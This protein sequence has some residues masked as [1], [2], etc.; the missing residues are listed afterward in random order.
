MT[1][2]TVGEHFNE[3]LLVH[4]R[5]KTLE[6][7]LKAAAQMRPG[8][9]EKDAREILSKI[10]K[11]MGSEAS[12][13]RAQLRLGKHTALGFGVKGEDTPVLQEN[14]IFFFDLGLV[15]KGHEGDVGR[16]FVVGN[17]PEMLRCAQDAEIIWKEVRDHWKSEG[18]TGEELY[19]F[20]HQSAEKRSWALQLKG[21]KGHRIADF[22]HI[23]RQ[24]GTISRQAATLAENRWILEIQIIHP[25]RGFG[26]FYEDLLS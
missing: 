25:T 12:W 16:P 20:A 6:V 18:A 10:E 15:F 9:S 4:A 23:A 26:A 7:L 13:H 11:E 24:R 14:D 1:P 22:P 17:D 8:H 5:D 3:D 21:A 19:E 2:E